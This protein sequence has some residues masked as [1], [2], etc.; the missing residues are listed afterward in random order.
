MG[1]TNRSAVPKRKYPTGKVGNYAAPVD[2]TG[3]DPDMIADL[4]G[5]KMTKIESAYVKGTGRPSAIEA[6]KR[7]RRANRQPPLKGS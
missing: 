4:T 1:Y 5:T 7:A 6:V 2:T 3:M